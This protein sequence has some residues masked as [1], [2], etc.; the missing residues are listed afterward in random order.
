M[1]A[2]VDSARRD[3]RAA[4]RDLTRAA[5]GD[6]RFLLRLAPPPPP[7][8][9]DTTL[10]LPRYCGWVRRLAGGPLPVTAQARPAA[11]PAGVLLSAAQSAPARLTTWAEVI[12]AGDRA[13]EAQRRIDRYDVEIHKKWA[14]S[15]ACFVF[16]LVG[17]A[18]ALRFP[19]GGMGLVIGGGTITFA[20]YYIG[21][22]AGESLADRALM[23]P[24]LAMWLPN[25]VLGAVGALG[26]TAV[27]RE[28]GSTRGGDW[29]EVRGWLRRLRP[30]R[31]PA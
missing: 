28:L 22:T 11:Q 25:I 15:V 1:L 8:E 30:R 21:L 6:L 2:V 31:R 5:D 16:V 23:S 20:L 26:V 14:I 17:V 19:R 7:P 13:R 3:L 10:R 29:N 4:R 27:S 12:A 24:W 18:L 9:P